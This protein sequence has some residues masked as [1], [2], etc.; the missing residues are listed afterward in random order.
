MLLSYCLVMYGYVLSLA[1]EMVQH[2]LF[3]P[4]NLITDR[5]NSEAMPPL[6]GRV[7]IFLSWLQ[8]F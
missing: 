7:F 5:D 4:D 1:T 2:S 3:S 6:K 8:A